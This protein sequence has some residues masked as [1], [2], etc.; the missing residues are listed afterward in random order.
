MNWDLIFLLATVGGA[1]GLHVWLNRARDEDKTPVL[2][3]DDE[4]CQTVRLRQAAAAQRME[5]LGIKTLYEGHRGW[6]RVNPM[7]A[8][9]E[10]SRVVPMRK[11]R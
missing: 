10:A 11:K 8:A 3:S 2:T 4:K 7:A 6:A 1:C 9:P 5:K